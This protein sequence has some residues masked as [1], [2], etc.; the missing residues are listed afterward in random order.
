MSSMY[1]PSFS[2]RILLVLCALAVVSL[3]YLPL[4]I[5]PQL[6][7]THHMSTAASAGVISAF[8]FAYAAGFL[9]F[10]PLS[11]RLGR[12]VVMMCGLAAL[13]LITAWL[14]TVQT[15]P[16]LLAGRAAQGLAAATFPPVVIAYL[17]ERGTPKQ[18]VWSVAWLST[19]F[20]SAGLL[21]QIYGAAV[22]S[23]W[24]LGSALL[25][26]AA[27]FAIT[28]WRLW[29]TPADP[30]HTPQGSLRTLYQPIGKL[31][32]SSPLRR[33]YGPALLLLMC[34]VAFYIGIDTHVG[35]ALQA[36]GITP[37][38]ARELAL[39]AFLTPLA[40]ASV[41]PRW[42]AERIVNTGLLVATSGLALSSWAG[43]G[44]LYGLLASS[45]IF[46]AGIGI[47]VPGLIARVASVAE[48][49][50][51]GLAVAFYT[52]VLFVGASLGPWL[53]QQ[54]AHWPTGQAFLLL[55]ILLGAAALYA[56]TGRSTRT[57]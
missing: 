34:F 40:V 54:T 29:T 2:L 22:A 7:Q 18:R 53:A 1:L 30:T 56:I 33:V 57:A 20:L 48:A 46:V 25:P 26:L 6:A 38:V 44:H 11:D 47:S 10:G 49:P 31:L 42:G 51:R 32:V 45:V 3:L 13:T 12:R 35:R 52:F 9:I 43:D 41:M 23:P 55:A 28:A 50:M 19:A 5:L 15:V 27:V 39:P 14:S 17:A 16:F 24:G 8:G 36:H 4:P 21:G 37:L